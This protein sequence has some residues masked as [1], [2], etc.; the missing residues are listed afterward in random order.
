M[1]SWDQIIDDHGPM[2]VRLAHRILGAGAGSEDEDIVQEVFLEALQLR[3]TE[4]I[5]SW[6]GVLYMMVIR[7]ALDRLRRRRP[8]ESL[9]HVEVPGVG[10]TP[11]ENAVARELSERLR[12]AV[13][14]LS[15][16]QATVFSLRYFEDLSHEEIAESLRMAPDAVRAALYRARA[17]LQTLLNVRIGGARR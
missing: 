16:E 12:K 13:A 4:K 1:V 14:E 5:R 11:F 7:R 15:D 17:R 9:D 2:M 3:Q 6:R 8:T 10:G